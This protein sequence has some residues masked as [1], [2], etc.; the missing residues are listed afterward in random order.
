[1]PVLD[2]FSKINLGNTNYVIY[3]ETGKPNIP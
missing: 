1:M 3:V 2:M